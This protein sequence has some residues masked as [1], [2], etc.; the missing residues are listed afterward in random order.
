LARG[1]RRIWAAG[2][3]HAIGRVNFL[4]DPAQRPHLRADELAALFGVKTQTMGN[5]GR[6]IMDTLR[7]SVLD[8]EWCREDMIEK[9]PV[10]WLIEID[11]VIMDARTL[12]EE[13]QAE[14]W[15][16]GLIPF[17]PAQA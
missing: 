2:I 8:P 16:L 6:L 15:R 12:P 3:V 1:D 4:S 5:K 14:A 17:V 11:G 10:V 7:I 9:N 13:I